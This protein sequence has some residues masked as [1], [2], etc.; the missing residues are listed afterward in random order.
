MQ[1]VIYSGV[2]K[3]TMVSRTNNS[4]MV[5]GTPYIEYPSSSQLLLDKLQHCSWGGESTSHL[6]LDI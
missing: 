5:W 4:W 1:V 2:K 6:L 3:N